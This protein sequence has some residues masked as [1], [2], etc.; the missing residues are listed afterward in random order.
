[1]WELTWSQWLRVSAPCC[2]QT[3]RAHLTHS[4][5]ML[6]ACLCQSITA[7]GSAPSLPQPAPSMP[8]PLGFS[9]GGC[10]HLQQPPALSPCSSLREALG[11]VFRAHRPIWEVHWA[12]AQT[13]IAIQCWA[14]VQQQQLQIRIVLAWR[15]YVL[16]SKCRN[17]VILA[18]CRFI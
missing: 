1:M 12:G 9:Q 2:C 8:D 6:A 13:D 10:Y 11:T 3:R 4:P 15:A 17:S 7:P 14:V 5:L 16:S 18:P